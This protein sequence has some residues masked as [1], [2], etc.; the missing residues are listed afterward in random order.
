MTRRKQHLIDSIQAMAEDWMTVK[1][2]SAYLKVTSA[3]LLRWVREGRLQG[4]KLSGTKRH[5]YRFLARDL[6]VA[7]T[8]RPSID[9]SVAQGVTQ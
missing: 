7:L 6:D 9:T 1:E 2:A 8:G 5:V 3:S 4:Y